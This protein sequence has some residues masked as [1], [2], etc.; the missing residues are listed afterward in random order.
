MEA[1][2]DLVVHPARRHRVERHRD[3]VEGLRHPW[4]AHRLVEQERERHRLRELRGAAEAAEAGIELRVDR[5][6][7]VV[8]HRG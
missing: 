6:H 7:R 3:R 2:T 1:A 4:V 5:A 8:E